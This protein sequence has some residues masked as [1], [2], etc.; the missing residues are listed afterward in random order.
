MRQ[1]ILKILHDPEFQNYI[2]SKNIL[3]ATNYIAKATIDDDIDTFYKIFKL[4]YDSG[5]KWMI[6]DNFD[7]WDIMFRELHNY[8]K[9]Y[10]IMTRVIIDSP[11]IKLG[12]Y[13]C[14]F[15]INYKADTV[16]SDFNNMLDD[17]EMELKAI[18]KYDKQIS[19]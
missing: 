4:C 8:C 5:L 11:W 17:L 3:K 1:A 10:N 12:L 15:A 18:L 13:Q 6:Q 19:L 9:Y 7:F 16:L 14:D 2:N